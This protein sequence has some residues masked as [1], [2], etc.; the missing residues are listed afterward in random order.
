MP[1][2][3]KGEITMKKF[4][5]AAAI[6]SAATAVMTCF[7][8]CGTNDYTKDNTTFFLGGTGPLTGENS[9]Y[10][11]SV[12]QGAELAVKVINDELGGLNDIKF[13][14]EM[15]DD[16]ATEVDAKN[17]FNTLFEKG[18]QA[19]IGSTTS[20]SCASFA[21]E[22]Y[23]NKVFFLTPSASN[24]AVIA[25]DNAF[26]V[27]FGDDQQG[28]LAADELKGY[29]NIGAIYDSSDTYSSDLFK[30]FKKRMT[31]NGKTFKEQSF[32]SET[33]KDFSTQVEALKDCDV[34]FL[35]IYY[36]EAS[37]IVKTCV[38]KGC[39]SDIFGCDGFDGINEMF[40]DADNITNSIKYITPFDAASTD[41]KVADFVT[42][43]KA[44][45]N[46]TPDQF[47]ADAYD[48]V[49][50]IYEAMKAADVKDVTISAA[51]LGDILKKQFTSSSF[52]YS[53]VTG[54]MTWNENGSCNKS[55]QIVSYSK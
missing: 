30:A 19:S 26:R 35:P 53:G 43:Y 33:A 51:D 23:A 24:E 15:I 5:K 29:E 1:I 45:Y 36:E 34:I 22:A 31:E 2:L 11:M 55:A 9:S 50:A 13:S 37:L 54:E 42:K 12:K 17:G 47:A 48:A 40:S 10:G 27:C 3:A 21:A 39:T 41:K 38:A 4:F 6:L 25:E 32:T 20:G 52:S 16:K 18:M 14:F 28:T 46:S 44:E 8:G 49:M 7:A